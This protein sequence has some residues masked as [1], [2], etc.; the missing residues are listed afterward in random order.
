MICYKDRW[1]CPFFKKCIAG[2]KCDRAL[3]DEVIADA[4]R[5]NLPINRITVEPECYIEA[6]DG[7]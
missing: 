3:T 7:D 1:F 4:V 6:D 2:K 5:I